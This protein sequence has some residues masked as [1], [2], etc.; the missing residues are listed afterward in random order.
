MEKD[1]TINDIS[2]KAK[3]KKEVYQVLTY[4]GGI[5]LPPILDANKNYIKDI[6]TGKKKFLYWKQ[7]LTVKVPHIDSLSIKQVLNFAKEW[8][9]INDYLP[10]YKYNKL[11][12][13]D[14]LWNVVN[15]L[16]NKEFSKFIQDR[17]AKREKC[18][19]T[20]MRLD[21]EAIP[22]IVN[23][24]AKSKNVSYMNGRTHFLMR[25]QLEN[26]KRKIHDIEMDLNE[27]TKNEIKNYKEKINDLQKEIEQYQRT[28]DDLLQD[29][30]KLCKL[31][32][33]GVIDSDGEPIENKD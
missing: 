19:I 23:I 20:K 15:T 6:M 14:W 27:E 7:I 5:Y 4:E 16:A 29:K 9:N 30:E 33:Y 26:R 31:Y 13:R 8:T 18:M 10:T 25:S 3:S 1:F 12:N 17:L 22:E 28:N 2:L 32:E 24:F 11:P 21:V